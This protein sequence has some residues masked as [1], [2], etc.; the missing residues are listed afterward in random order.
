MI[1]M[2]V[3]GVRS[4]DAGFPL[5]GCTVH[6]VMIQRHWWNGGRS[7]RFRRDVYIRSDGQRWDVLAQIGGPAGRSRVHEC[8]SGSSA[9]IVANAWRGSDS[10]WQEVVAS[11]QP[12]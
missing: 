9:L 7:T 1:L 6:R 4:P 5:S 2:V 12:S 8:P 3:D 10:S 11:T